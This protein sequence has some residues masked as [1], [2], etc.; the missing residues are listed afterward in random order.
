MQWSAHVTSQLEHNGER[1]AAFAC[2][3]RVEDSGFAATSGVEWRLPQPSTR[4]PNGGEL[5]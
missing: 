2:D 4:A 5:E 3:K 1:H